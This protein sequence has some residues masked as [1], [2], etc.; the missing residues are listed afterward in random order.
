MPLTTRP[1]A[2]FLP[3]VVWA[4][5]ID[6]VNIVGILGFLLG[7][8][9]AITNEAVN[10]FELFA[11]IMVFEDADVFIQAW[12]LTTFIPGTTLLD[13]IPTLT[14]LHFVGEDVI[15]KIGQIIQMEV[16]NK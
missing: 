4:L 8:A 5:A 12:E 2:K 13:V 15:D 1:W 6:A 10:L 3:A 16:S 7:P 11:A 14:L 9:E